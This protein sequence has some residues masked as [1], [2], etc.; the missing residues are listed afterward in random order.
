MIQT[1][2][3]REWFLD[4]KSRDT[5]IRSQD[6]DCLLHVMATYFERGHAFPALTQ[7]SVL[8]R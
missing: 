6:S 1:P 4:S 5:R 2:W 7:L 3:G 8:L